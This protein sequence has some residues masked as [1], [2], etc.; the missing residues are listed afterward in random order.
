MARE[1]LSEGL[2]SQSNKYYLRSNKAKVKKIEPVVRM[3]GGRA[4]HAA[5]SGLDFE[6]IIQ[7][8]QFITFEVKETH[9]DKLPTANIRSSQSITAQ[10]QMEFGVEPF[11]L[12]YFKDYNEWYYLSFEELEKILEADYVGIPIRFFRAFGLFVPF[13]D[14]SEKI[15]DYL[16]PEGYPTSNRLK[17]GFPDV[18]M[19]KKRQKRKVQS[20]EGPIDYTNKE[21][22]EARLKKAIQ[23]GIKNAEKKEKNTKL[24]LERIREKRYGAKGRRS[25]ED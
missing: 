4:I 11:L 22:R 14:Y 7:G 18:W 25:F 6:G 19:G 24:M 1:T 9:G 5:S 16:H 23:R 17:E 10:R 3:V 20:S 21:A 2:V 8:G 15:P 12:V 13:I